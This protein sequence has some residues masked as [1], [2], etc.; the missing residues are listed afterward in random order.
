MACVN[1]N[2][3]DFKKTSKR[4]NIDP[5]ILEGIIDGYWVTYPKQEQKQVF[6]SDQY[7]LETLRLGGV[8]ST[9]FSSLQEYENAHT[10]WK[11]KYSNIRTFNNRF[12][13][14]DYYYLVEKLFGQSNVGIIPRL[15]NTI[16]VVVLEPQNKIA[17]IE[18]AEEDLLSTITDGLNQEID[19]LSNSEKKNIKD[20]EAFLSSNVMHPAE[21]EY[22]AKQTIAMFSNILDQ[23]QGLTEM[24]SSQANELYFKGKY[25]DV[26]FS[27]MSRGAIIQKLGP[28]SIFNI[29]KEEFFNPYKRDDI[30]DESFDKLELAYLNFETLL[31]CGYHKL[32]NNEHISLVGN[33]NREVNDQDN[34]EE[35]TNPQN[36]EELG[37]QLEKYQIRAR[38]ISVR[39]SLSPL[40]RRAFDKLKEKD[41]NG[42]VII[43]QFGL[44]KL[45]DSDIVYNTILASVRK[46]TTI[47]QME[48]ILAETVTIN[49]WMKEVL[50]LIKQEPFR[51][52]FYQN[53]RKDFSQ[54]SIVSREL[55]DDGNYKFITHIINTNDLTKSILSTVNN[56][57]TSGELAIIYN[58]DPISGYGVI[59]PD[60]VN[61][62]KTRLDAIMSEFRVTNKQFD[63]KELQ[64]ISDKYYKEVSSILQTLGIS[65]NDVVIRNILSGTTTKSKLV[66]R[67]QAVGFKVLSSVES[68]LTNMQNTKNPNRYSL[69]GKDEDSVKG[70]YSKIA[71]DT[72]SFME[73]SVE[74][75]TYENGKMYYSYVTPSYLGKLVLNLKNSMGDIQGFNKFIEDNY[76]KYNWFVQKIV[77]EDGSVKEEHSNEWLRLLSENTENGAKM[78]NMFEHKVQLHYN[79][80]GYT[81]LSALDYSISLIQEFFSDF[82]KVPTYAWYHVPILADKPSA[83]FIKFRRYTDNNSTTVGGYEKEIVSQLVKVA[84]QELRRMKTVKERAS[85]DVEKIHSFDKNGAEFKFLDFLNSTFLSNDGTRE[86]TLVQE[87]LNGNDSN[88]NELTKLLGV[89]IKTGLENKFQQA[90]ATWEKIGV[91][92][93]NKN[94]KTNKE[95]L[96]HLNNIA[97]NR[98]EAEKALKNY[99][100]NSY[101]A[102]TE[103]IQLTVTDIAFYENTEDFQKRFAQI[104]SP[105]LRFNVSATDS[106]GVRYTQDGIERTMYIADEFISSDILNVVEK[107]FDDKVKSA[108][109]AAQKK[110]Y[111]ALRDSVVKGFKNINVTD[112]QAYTTLKGYRKKMGQAGKWTP[113]MEAALER[114]NNGNMN[115]SDL[116]IIC[117]PMKPFV[118]TQIAKQSYSKVMEL[119]KVPVQN[120]NSE[121][122]LIMAGAI[123]ASAS[124][125]GKV[126]KLKAISDFMDEN[127]ID[128]VQFG[129]AVKSGKMGVIDI[130]GANS[131]EETKA[132][133]KA[134][135]F[136]IDPTTDQIITDAGQ[137]KY[138]EQ[139]VHEIPFEDYGIQQEVPEHLMDASQ[140]FGSQIRKLIMA[141]ITPGTLFK[142]G[143]DNISKEALIEEYQQLIAANVESS[144][145]ELVKALKLDNADLKVKNKAISELLVE[146]IKTNS[147]YGP[148]LLRACSLNE[149]GDFV[150]PLADPT[151][152]YRIQ[153][154]MNSIIKSRITKQKIKGGAVVQVS[155]Y[156]LS[157][158]L[159]IIFNEDGSIKYFECYMP[160]YSKEFLEDFLDENGQLNIESLPE[161]LRKLIGYRIPTEDKYSMAPLYIKGFLAQESGSAIMLPKEITLLSGSDYDIDKMYVML[162]EF[163]VKRSF[164]KGSFIKDFKKSLNIRTDFDS[165]D[166]AYSQ[167]V[168]REGKDGISEGS[169]EDKMNKFYQANKKKY[170]TSTYTKTKYDTNLSPI[171]QSTA[172]RNNRIID[173][174]YS[175]LTN[176]DTAEKI[177][178]PGS[179]DVQKKSS[180]IITILKSTKDYSYNDLKDL[181]LGELN[182]IIKD[183][184][185]TKI[186]SI[187]DPTTQV[188]FHQ[189]NT[190][191]GKLI[192][193]FANHNSSHAIIQLQDA[194]FNMQEDIVFDGI[195]FNSIVAS[196]TDMVGAKLDNVYA[197]DG[198]TYIGKNNAGFLA[199]SVDAVKDPVLNFMNLNTYTANVAMVLSRLGFDPD[200]IGLLLTQPIIEK[201]TQEYFKKSNENYIT[202][203]SVVTEAINVILKE[204]G[205]GVTE[206]AIS[207]NLATSDFTKQ[208]LA[209]HLNIEDSVENKQ[210]EL[211]TLVLFKKLL[212]MGSEL[213]ELTFITK[214]DTVSNA[215]GPTIAD[216]MA[217]TLRVSKFMKRATSKK[218][219]FTQS[220]YEV[221]ERSPLLN[222]FYKYSNQSSYLMFADNFP[223]FQADFVAAL[224]LLRDST[225]ADIDVKTV[226]KFMNDFISFK[227]TKGLGE[228]QVFNGDKE[229]RNGYIQEFAPIFQEIMSNPALANNALIKI[230][231]IKPKNKKNPMASISAKVGGLSSDAIES[232][233]NA[234]ADL[235]M[236]EETREIALHLFKYNFYR[237]GFS[238]SPTS[239]MHLVPIEVKLAVPNYIDSLRST[240]TQGIFDMDMDQ[241]NSFV[242]QFKRNYSWDRRIVPNAD[243]T[244]LKIAQ[245]NQGTISISEE[246]NPELD[247]II[248][249]DNDTK[250]YADMITLTEVDKNKNIVEN[251]YMNVSDRASQPIYQ[252]ISPL[253]FKNNAQEY[254][255][256][257]QDVDVSVIPENLKAR[258]T[259]SNPDNVSGM[260]AQTMEKV[261][262][263]H[264]G[265]IEE[266]LS[267]TSSLTTEQAQEMIG[268]TKDRRSKVIK[269]LRASYPKFESM[270]NATKTKLINYTMNAKLKDASG[271]IIC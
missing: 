41:E 251:F 4:L 61:A 63:K 77:Q 250:V 216:S 90:L 134:H 9:Q 145:N 179:F 254:S 173:L 201:V 165:L 238:F 91:L 263:E 203:D 143:N 16:D 25:S 231:E 136:A 57:L 120:K 137:K 49:P 186:K 21:R 142:V 35:D 180:R 62:T 7:I 225:K 139:Y 81:D 27:S 133:L 259:T 29:I 129:T 45:M 148:E 15:D 167:V 192:G 264:S 44:P 74:S 244:K 118:Y 258:I 51:S 172:A 246:A 109:N 65:L 95:T 257:A 11:Q 69:L 161:E 196:D 68:I 195:S 261:Y 78:R 213:N 40:I 100:Y 228:T 42:Q 60:I 18:K 107:M 166:I 92:D 205:G 73:Q 76:T 245:L 3:K 209:R 219:P 146:E 190:T 53:F 207:D 189:Q 151:Q 104:H 200:S 122:V 94:L 265:V 50:E 5:K 125:G 198:F 153:Q 1:V 83:E 111:I 36:F 156:G 157:N 212:K 102:T 124:Q 37:S 8:S 55:D 221:L 154:L 174:M 242:Q 222:A 22:L 158:D 141:D 240:S 224:E 32:V 89:H 220:T 26:D 128:T 140:L 72:T 169:L 239:F 2:D 46:A 28:M 260:D 243:S 135:T 88:A 86:S 132:I 247:K 31:D 71:T 170:T 59:N 183:K 262:K 229:S 84:K 56:L 117:Q 97:A 66:G 144:F 116:D 227:L 93:T 130:N 185:F 187:V 12:E 20:R 34:P 98:E 253:G 176:R 162:P 188:A 181:N 184:G 64:K 215:V 138:N 177:F 270:D 235:Y 75:S 147:R 271:E 252:K 194:H 13:A 210:Y 178:N 6:P 30:S 101:F 127:D 39:E 164:D 105:A 114:I 163:D 152:S 67:E 267:I 54:Y 208:E 182:K 14:K 199:A 23:L 112:A 269:V 149:E 236:N 193:I 126:N 237:S 234:W 43:D 82:S 211:E 99:F 191:A 24:P 202:S 121:Y 113:A 19:T 85:L 159:E 268:V 87:Y 106:K 256:R 175:V 17:T 204:L 110:G 150:I 232:I 223:H 226:N 52:Q 47:E 241:I 249:S 266:I 131:E 58:V 80:V 197:L 206:K 214:Y 168:T 119:L 123:A 217:K 33:Y 218:A 255:F 96:T 155:P 103:I 160:A 108:K 233:K 79:N 48:S 171:S 10:L 70:F 248:V 115:L 38:S 230:L